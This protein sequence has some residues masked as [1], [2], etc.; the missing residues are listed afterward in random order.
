[1]NDMTV[2]SLTNNDLILFGFQCN[3][4]RGKENWQCGASASGGATSS[5][6]SVTSYGAVPSSSR[7]PTPSVS[8]SRKRFKKLLSLRPTSVPSGS[9]AHTC[10]CE[11]QVQF[12]FVLLTDTLYSPLPPDLLPP[13]ATKD[14]EKRQFPRTIVA[15]EVQDQKNGATHYWTLEKL[16]YT[17]GNRDSRPIY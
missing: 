15:V 12:Q 7:R 16:R 1:M 9:A 8:S 10:F 4:L 13:E 17:N 14:R 3:G 6:L 11:T 2:T 5:P